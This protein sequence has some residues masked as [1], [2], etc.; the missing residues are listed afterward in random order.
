MVLLC[1]SSSYARTKEPSRVEGTTRYRG[2][3]KTVHLIKWILRV[4]ISH[5]LRNLTSYSPSS[6]ALLGECD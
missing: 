1:R 5:M 6:S 4:D 2:T 3:R